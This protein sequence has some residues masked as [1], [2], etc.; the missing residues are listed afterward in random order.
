MPVPRPVD[1][2]DCYLRGTKI[3]T[4]N[5]EVAI[6]DLRAGDRLVTR[7]GGLRPLQWVGRQSFNGRFL[8]KT[9]APVCFHAGSIADNVPSRD[10]YVSP[11][12]SMVIDDYLVGAC[13]LVNGV[14]ISQTATDQIVDYFHL[15][16]GVHDCVIADGAWSE[17]Y[18]E[19]HNRHQ[20]HNL[21]AFKAEF[22]DHR[23]VPQ[24][25][26]LPQLG[27]GDAGLAPV[28]AQLLA[29]VPAA[30]F[31]TD[32]D[33]HLMVDGVRLDPTQRDAAGWMFDVPTGAVGVRLMSRASVPAMGGLNADER[34]LGIC[35]ERLIIVDGGI[36]LT[37]EPGHPALGAGMHDPEVLRTARWTNG[38]CLLPDLIFAGYGSA[39]LL[40]LTVHGTTLARY[41]DAESAPSRIAA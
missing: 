5:G 35:I 12:H 37:M 30:A 19:Q 2:A 40:R 18:A 23:A 6:E 32:A 3:L 21:A 4:A 20:F 7:F 26:C 36:T 22:P 38:I 39:T 11:A 33:V 8:G 25:Y 28:R 27:F 16:F 29:R 24:P 41:L 31:T 13:L 1:S 17:S 34:L 15:D 9:N 10:L 14:T